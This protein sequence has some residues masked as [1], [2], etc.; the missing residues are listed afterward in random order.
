MLLTA[1][2]DINAAETVLCLYKRDGKHII[3]LQRYSWHF[4][5]LVLFEALE[6]R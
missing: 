1:S 2:V 5:E 3:R 6:T 4:D